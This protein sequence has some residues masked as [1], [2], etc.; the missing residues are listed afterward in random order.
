MPTDDID[1]YPVHITDSFQLFCD[2]AAHITLTAPPGVAMRVDVLEGE[3]PIG[4]AVSRDGAA[5]TVDLSDPS[6]L[7][8]D[9]T[10]LQARVSW[11]GDARSATPYR[12]ERS[13]SY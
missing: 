4:T 7:G 9:T 10:D 11:V 1:V 5:A 6:C 2:G 8:D 13:G 12:L 3:T